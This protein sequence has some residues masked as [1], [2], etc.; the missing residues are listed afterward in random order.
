MTAQY[1][2]RR[3]ATH[4]KQKIAKFDPTNFDQAW[5]RNAQKIAEAL[6]PRPV[7]KFI[8][9]MLCAWITFVGDGNGNMADGGLVRKLSEISKPFLPVEMPTDQEAY[10]MFGLLMPD[11]EP[12]AGAEGWGMALFA[13]LKT[14][15]D[16]LNGRGDEW[17][18]ATDEVFGPQNR[19]MVN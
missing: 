12:E 19:R 9:P 2:T 15:I 7:E 5:A 14:A 16:C 3:A 10:Q 17:Q 8:H 1:K 11:E 13:C 6:K 4:A 18:R